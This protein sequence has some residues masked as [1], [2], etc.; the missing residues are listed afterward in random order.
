MGAWRKSGR[1]HVPEA[2][3]ALNCR[4]RSRRA[5]PRSQG[6]RFFLVRRR[7]QAGTSVSRSRLYLFVVVSIAERGIP[8]PGTK[9]AACG[10]ADSDPCRRWGKCAEGGRGFAQSRGPRRGTPHQTPNPPGAFRLGNE[11]NS[12]HSASLV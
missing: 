8:A 2:S 12:S 4:Q 9:T 6:K 3:P 1:S 7:K 10:T 5:G 11:E